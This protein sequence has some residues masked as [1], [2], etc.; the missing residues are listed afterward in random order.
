MLHAKVKG[1]PRERGRQHGEALRAEIRKV[2]EIWVAP[3]FRSPLQKEAAA[4]R[5]FLESRFPRTVE[6]LRGIAEGASLGEE[7]LF[8]LNVFNSCPGVYVEPCCTSLALR[9]RDGRVLVGK[10]QDTGV[11][12]SI[13]QT[14]LECEDERGRRVVLCGLAGTVWVVCGINDRGLAVGCNS[15]PPPAEAITGE[16]LPQHQGYY[17]VLWECA[18]VDEAVSLLARTPFAGKGINAVMADAS[19]EAA[20]VEKAGRFQAAERSRTR[21]LW[22]TNHYRSPALSCLNNP[23]LT[24]YRSSQ[25]RGTYLGRRVGTTALDDPEATLAELLGERGF[26]GCLC[27]DIPEVELVTHYGFVMDPA[28]RTLRVSEGRPDRRTYRTYG[29]G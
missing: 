26:V 13:H 10:T 16:G 1:T 21:S 29:T 4:M 25:D 9:G 2:W 17:P 19:G 24:Y 23:A 11:E 18:T 6:E 7:A 3:H 27:Q 5:R 15:G 22:L 8:F 14:I 12:E 20:A 28:A